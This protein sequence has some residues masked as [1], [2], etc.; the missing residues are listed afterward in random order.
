MCALVPLTVPVYALPFVRALTSGQLFHPWR[1]GA[2]PNE[3]ATLYANDA[4]APNEGGG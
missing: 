3:E 4:A 1:P 2:A